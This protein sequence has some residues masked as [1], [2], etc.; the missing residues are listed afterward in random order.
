MEKIERT[1]KMNDF[2][3]VCKLIEKAM[4]AK[5]NN[6]L[7]RNCET[8]QQKNVIK[9]LNDYGIYGKDACVFL[10]KLMAATTE[11]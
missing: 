7:L 10:E 3:M 11:E 4:D 1:E 8:Q 2:D 9:L 5:I 6:E